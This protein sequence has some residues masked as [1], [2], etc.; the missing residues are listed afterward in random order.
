MTVG[1]GSSGKVLVANVEYIL[2]HFFMW[3]CFRNSKNDIK[4]KF[5][6]NPKKPASEL[7]VPRNCKA[8]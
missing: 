2:E 8:I 6:K 5:K 4:S 7:H 3:I 1:P